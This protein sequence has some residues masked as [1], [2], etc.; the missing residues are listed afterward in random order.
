M[1]P[2]DKRKLD[3]EIKPTGVTDNQESA[4]AESDLSKEEV[5]EK[6]EVK[7]DADEGDKPKFG[8]RR[9]RASSSG[10]LTPSS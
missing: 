3:R 9:R 4:S 10:V 1:E 6:V 8:R 5:S 2:V 7:S